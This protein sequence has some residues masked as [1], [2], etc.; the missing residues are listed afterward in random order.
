MTAP[1]VLHVISGFR[2]GGAESFLA[3]LSSRLAKRGFDQRI[4]GLSG[5]GP[6]AAVFEANGLPIHR[7]D[8]HGVVNGVKVLRSV[9]QLI[10]E[11]RPHIVQGWMYHGD[12]FSA[13]AHR[14]AR[15][16]DTRLFWNVRCSDMRLAD[17]ALQLRLLVRGCIALSSWPELVIVNSEAGAATHIGA[18]YHPR[19]MEVI[20]NGVDVDR[21]RPDPAVRREV[22][23]ELGIAETTRVIVHAARVDPMKDHP[24]LL[25]SVAGLPDAL[26]LLIG[27]GTEALDLPD[28]VM[29]LGLRRDVDRL[30]AAGDIVVS[31]SAYGEGFSNAV[32]E[33]M[34]TGL[35]PVATRTG[36]VEDIIGSTGETLPPA[37]RGGAAQGA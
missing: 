22:R 1:R 32:A 28:G 26:T 11:Y 34:A 5:D 9:A 27:K 18:G 3:Q 12:F 33:G 36:D 15:Q 13:V 20:G 24:T 6:M 35:V 10:R 16:H 7:L 4:V 30:L 31:S 37:L 19:R 8:A 29:A 17:Y 2:T 25:A 23:R 14:I 21:F